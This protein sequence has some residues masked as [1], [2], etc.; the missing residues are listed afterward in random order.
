MRDKIFL[1]AFVSA[2]V[3]CQ[4]IVAGQWIAIAIL[5]ILIGVLPVVM[6]MV[7]PPAAEVPPSPLLTH[8]Q[9][10]AAKRFMYSISAAMLVAALMATWQL[11]A[12]PINF[13]PGNRLGSGALFCTAGVF[14]L[15]IHAALL[16][17]FRVRGP[18]RT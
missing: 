14:G 10:R 6:N 13:T 8:D 15:A 3:A 18:S 12:N 2:L 9:A 11:L 4:T 5:G 1:I 17:A 7:A 16:A